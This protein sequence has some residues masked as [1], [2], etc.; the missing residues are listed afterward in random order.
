MLFF[1]NTIVK[2]QNK[3]IIFYVRHKIVDMRNSSVGIDDMA[4]YIPKLYLPIKTLAEQ[5]NI[6]FDKLNKGLGLTA[7]AIPDVH[8]DS[9]T[10]AA[11]AVLELIEKNNLD[12]KTIGRL[13]LG[14]E[15]ALDGA[16]P[17]ATYVLE[18]LRSKLAPTYGADCFLNCDVVDLTF[19]CVGGVDALHNTLDWVKCGADR[20]GI[21]VTSDF[22]KYE[23][24]STGEYTQ[25]AGAISLLVKE[26]PRLVVIESPI[27]VATMGVHDFFKPQR[28][29]S[30]LSIVEEVMNLVGK[31]GLSPEQILG[32]MEDSLQVKGFLDDNDEI[33]TIHKD[34]PVFDGPYSNLTYQKRIRE[35]FEHFKAQ[36]LKADLWSKDELLLER[37][38][39]LIFHLPYAFHGKR[40]F[41]ELYKLELQKAGQ[42]EALEKSL[43]ITE[44]KPSD[45]E[46]DAS[47][48]KAYAGYLKAISK[49]PGYR[50]VVKNKIV[51]THWASGAIGNMY[52]GS[53]F[54]ALMSSLEADLDS[55]EPLEEKSIGFLGYGSGSK[56]K[57]FEGVLQS[58]WKEVAKGF[59]IQQKLD[60]RTDID[61]VTYE[62]LHRLKQPQ[63]INPPQEEFYLK[64]IG[65]EG[66]LV[67]ARYYEW[68]GV[69]GDGGPKLM[70]VKKSVER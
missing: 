36:A 8:E 2:T 43:E 42:L 33:I 17:T 28:S 44:P 54:L 53:I 61:Y 48:Q 51:P 68:S 18:M 22:A 49:S 55:A 26:N 3:G 30:K 6:A 50:E 15:S 37:W 25:G 65:T 47:Y 67:G 41:T 10:M 4:L 12:P 52:A 57:V 5:R 1:S 64:S 31:N 60:A 20:I 69:V 13:Y 40:I 59:N 56:S 32:R 7:M 62:K 38:K 29:V 66:N 19:A 9:A 21:V 35:A 70:E 16:K 23:L 34:T 45:F 58:G 39:R 14:T 11:N 63:S 46:N 24:D 27:G